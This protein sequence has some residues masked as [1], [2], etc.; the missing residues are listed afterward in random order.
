M[1]ILSLF[2]DRYSAGLQLAEII[3]KARP[4]NPIVYGIPRGGVLVAAAI[5]QQLGYP[6]DI[7]IAKK[8]VL[9]T[10][11]ETALG[12]ITADGY[13]L[14]MGSEYCT[15]SE[16][17]HALQ[18]ARTKA[19]ELHRAFQPFRPHLEIA[20][21]TAILVDDGIATGA[22]ISAIAA[23]MRTMPYKEIWL[24]A[25]VAPLRMPKAIT[26]RIDQVIVL[27]RPEIFVSVSHFYRH[28]SEVTTS[29][30]L[31]YFQAA[32]LELSAS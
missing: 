14:D 15:T 2:E 29:E 22:T 10:N 21:T 6:L 32:N 17:S 8:I 24:A 28:F 26:S 25:P 9:P 1:K 4:T 11:P 3:V 19:E 13:M 31:S 23:A 12:A 7:A 20:D 30:S 18:Y 27:E 5:A 16:W